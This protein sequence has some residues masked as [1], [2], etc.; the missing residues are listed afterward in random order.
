M[1]APARE[2]VRSALAPPRMV[3]I[4]CTI[5]CEGHAHDVSSSID[6]CCGGIIGAS[7]EC[8][9]TPFMVRAL[10][11]FLLPAVDEES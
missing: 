6:A 9:V 10:K 8:L 11:P 1:W 4:P 5:C 7:S 2:P 3:R